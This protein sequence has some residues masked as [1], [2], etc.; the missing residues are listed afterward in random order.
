LTILGQTNFGIYGGP[1]Y[2]D[3]GQTGPYCGYVEN[4]AWSD[5]VCGMGL[6][7]N[8]HVN[9]ILTFK[10]VVS[11][12]STS[13]PTATPTTAITATPT[14]GPGTPTVTPALSGNLAPTIAAQYRYMATVYAGMANQLDPR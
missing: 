12:S 2:L 13:T 9:F 10:R 8:R 14:P 4:P 1:V 3:Q 6:P 7:Y 5:K 11:D